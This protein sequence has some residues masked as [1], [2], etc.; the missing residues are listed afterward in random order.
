MLYDYIIVG[1][2]SAGCV[3]ANR[4]SANPAHTVLLVEAGKKDTHPL[5]HI[6]GGYSELNRSEVDWAFWTEPQEQLDNRKLYLPRGKTWGGSSSTNAMAYVRGNKEDYNEWAAL[7]NEGWSYE[8]VL[9]FFKKSEHN[10]QFGEPFHNQQGELNV[11]Y[12]HQIPPLANEFVKACTQVGIPAVAD[13]NGAEQVGASILQFTIKNNARHSTAAAFLKPVLQ[14][15]NLHIISNTRVHKVI[16]EN[17]RATGIEV[18]DAVGGSKQYFA[19]KEVILAAGAFQSPQ[20]LLLSG[21]GDAEEL[22]AVGIECKHALPGVGKNLQDHYWSGVS[23]KTNIPTSN[24]LLKPL[25][26]MAALLKY[27]FTKKGPLGNS[28]LEANAFYCSQP[29][30]N[31]PDIQFH[32]ASL[33]IAGDYSTDIYDLKTFSREDGMGILAIILHPK[34]RGYVGLRSNRPDDAPLIQPN[35]FQDPADRD[36][37]V[38]AVKKA[39]EIVQAPALHTFMKGEVTLPAQQDDA[40]L[41]EHIKK[42]LET[43]YH[44]VGTCKMGNDPMAVVDAQLKVRGIEGLRVIDASIMPTIVSGNTN[45]PTI[46]IAEKGAH[47]ILGN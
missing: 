14:R 40:F 28:P 41:V 11:T 4:L 8:D 29:Q 1:A 3:L 20:I 19:S 15:K 44:P 31:R 39:I 10:Q 32:F 12:A 47:M 42:T 16:L 7:G 2:G 30:D 9:P 33:G 22:K 17:N 6:P 36:L 27:I 34:S 24:S 5:I 43:L 21:I 38:A 26:K 35:L 18:G 23:C 37:L 45:A 13:Y 46:M 25:N